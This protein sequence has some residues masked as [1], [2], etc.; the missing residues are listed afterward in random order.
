[1]SKKYEPLAATIV[2]EVGGPENIRSLHHCQT[3]LRFDL[4]DPAKA[5]AAAIQAIDGVAT[6]LASG[7]G[8]QV[9]IGLHVEEVNEEVE[10][11]LK[12]ANVTVVEDAEPG[13]KA[14]QGPVGAFI[15]FMAGVFVPIIPAFAGAGMVRALLAILVTFGITPRD[16]QTYILFNFFAGAVFYFLPILLAF[17]AATKLK[18]NPYLAA[19]TAAIMLHPTWNGLV[20]AGEPVQ[21]FDVVPL[22]LTEYGSSV[23]PILLV[24]WVQSYV[25]RF[26]NRIMPAAVKIVFVPLFTILIMGSLALALLGPIGDLI[27]GW[28]SGGFTFLATELSWAPPLLLGAFWAP[29]VVLGIHHSVGPLGLAQIASVGY[30]NLVGPGIMLANV[31]Q[32]IAALV[33][34]WRVHDHRVRQLASASGITALMGVTEPVLYG[35]NVPK[36][37]PLIAGCVGAASGG[38]VAGLLQVRRFAAGVSGLPALPMYIGDDSF[39]QLWNILIALAIAIVVTAVLTFFLSI[40]YERPTVIDAGSANDLVDAD[41]DSS[42]QGTLTDGA[43]AAVGAV[44]DVLTKTEVTSPVTGRIVE[45]ADLSDPVFASGAMGPGV[46][47]V[48]IDGE[49]LSPVT[50]TVIVAMKTGH[51]FGIRTDDGVELLVHVG[52]DT[53][54][55]NGKGFS[56]PVVKGARVAAGQTLVTADLDT[57]AAA[58]Y[59]PTVILIV[60]NFKKV[61][62]VQTLTTDADVIAGEPVLTV[63]PAAAH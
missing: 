7:T 32:G 20:E 29:M 16:S 19:V 41:T 48:P 46:G 10:R 39:Q 9:V 26:L 11:I 25:E 56:N 55:L 40:R 22:F 33:V 49:I 5:D 63:A 3:R 17:S 36:R 15:D 31:S 30:D 50:G 37:Y 44:T 54:K 21:L 60:T 53:V 47:V 59:D 38:I 45:L 12:A 18:C 1:M 57:I 13:G 6:T 43:P 42:A 35:V 14:K 28:I 61:G 52:V 8:L 23:V 58:G 4:K 51:A 34:A 62:P 27:G 2:E 24:V